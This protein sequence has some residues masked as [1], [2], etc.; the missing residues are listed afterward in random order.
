MHKHTLTPFFPSLLPF[1]MLIHSPSD[2]T[3]SA[4]PGQNQESGTQSMSVI[5]W[6]G[7][8]YLNHHLLPPQL[9]INKK[10]ELEVEPRSEPT[11][12]KSN[13]VLTITS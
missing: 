4:W 12:S 3:A 5:G 11:I 9:C 8:R 10:V 2:H 1:H 7:P 6:L 13:V